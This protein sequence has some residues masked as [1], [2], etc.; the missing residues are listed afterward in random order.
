MTSIGD[1]VFFGCGSLE[2]VYYTGTRAQW[3]SITTGEYNDEL[4]AAELRF[5]QCENN[6]HTEEIITGVPASC[7]ESGLTAG[8]RCAVCEIILEAQNLIPAG[9]TP[10]IIPA[11]PA[12]CTATGLTE[13]S[14][15]LI[16]G[17]SL[18]DQQTVPKKAHSW[19]SGKVTKAA[20]CT[21][22][23]AKLFTC[24]VCKAKKTKVI[25]VN[26]RHDW[27]DWTKFNSTEHIRF[28]SYNTT[29]TEKANHSWDSGKVTKEA[30]YTADGE[31]TFSCSGCGATKTE[32]IA[33]LTAPTVA[34]VGGLTASKTTKSAIT[35]KWNSAKNATKYQVYRSTDNGETWKKIATVAKT[36]YTDKDVKAGAKYQYKVR[37]LHA[38]SKATGKFS[39]VLKTG[40]VTAEPK[41]SDLTSTK[42][43]TAKV[44]WGKVSGAKS[45]TIYTSTDGKTFKAVKAGVTKTSYTITDLKSGKKVYV[46]VAAVNAYGA[47]SAQSAA[48]SVKVK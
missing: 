20:T 40:T 30:T 9:H 42:S 5:T 12:T 28:C 3:N 22:E 17:V 16:C 1:S 24:S 34:K 33:K 45:Y 21:E 44:T 41:I 4:S 36:G 23:G 35:L 15:C 11:V 39:A 38:E 8:K 2:T 25:A 29:H 37:G 46:K 27:S 13:G 6:G 14:K 47:E 10:E 19:D 18:V 7:T 26:G 31:K 32:T 43:K 48:K